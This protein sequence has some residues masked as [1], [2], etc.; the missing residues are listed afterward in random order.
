[1]VSNDTQSTKTYL[2]NSYV[3]LLI[4]FNFGYLAAN[5]NFKYIHTVCVGI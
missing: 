3:L 1:M 4:A 5:K 2:R